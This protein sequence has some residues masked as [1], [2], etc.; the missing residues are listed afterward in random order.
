MS[1]HYWRLTHLSQWL[2]LLGV[3]T[4][5]IPAIA[6]AAHQGDVLE[7]S[8]GT[9][10]NLPHYSY[11]SIQSLTVTDISQ[12]MLGVAQV[13]FFDDLQLQYKQPQLMVKFLLADS[14][15]M[16]QQGGQL[17][18]LVPLPAAHQASSAGGLNKD[19]TRSGAGRRGQEQPAL[20]HEQQQQEVSD[21]SRSIWR[22]KTTRQSAGINKSSAE[23]DSS[24]SSSDT[25][26]TL[27]KAFADQA[28]ENTTSTTDSSSSWQWKRRP[29]MQQQLASNSC[30][31]RSTND[32]PSSSS[33][34]SN[35]PSSKFLPGSF[36]TVVD[37]F[38]LCSCQDPVQVTLG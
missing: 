34:S 24:S 16:L 33:S 11:S 1:A 9:G 13:K 23:N 6:A 29:P 35:L 4:A 17:P 15:D 26:G 5:A 14:E 18:A 25:S 2:A 21:G 27:A 28:A 7:I 32:M 19:S 37:T 12:P 30:C 20:C 38:G 8:A 10:R 22:F 31:C 36:D 3:I